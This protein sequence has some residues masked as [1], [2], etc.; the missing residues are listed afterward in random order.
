MNSEEMVGQ[1][2]TD[3]PSLDNNG[4]V[5]DKATETWVVENGSSA[6]CHLY[7]PPVERL[8]RGETHLVWDSPTD[9]AQSDTVKK[10]NSD[11]D[12]DYHKTQLHAHMYV[13]GFSDDEID[14]LTV[15]DLIHKVREVYK[16][17]QVAHELASQ[18]Y[19]KRKN[20]AMVRGIRRANHRIQVASRG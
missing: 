5:W 17:K 12:Y 10:Y 9:V 7:G 11:A 15:D 8:P 2:P 18:V 19:I 13:L 16:Y 6:H 14:R 20:I 4:V 3:Y 1:D